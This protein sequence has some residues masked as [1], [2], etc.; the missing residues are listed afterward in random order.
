MKSD[1]HFAREREREKTDEGTGSWY[2]PEDCS[3]IIEP[4]LSKDT[5]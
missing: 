1:H 4:L 2:I 5:K 3:N